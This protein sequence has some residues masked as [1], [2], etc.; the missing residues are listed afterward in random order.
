M[1]IGIPMEF[2]RTVGSRYRVRSRFVTPVWLMVVYTAATE[3]NI[4]NRKYSIAKVHC[5]PQLEQKLSRLMPPDLLAAFMAQSRP[6]ALAWARGNGRRLG[7]ASKTTSPA[8]AGVPRLVSARLLLLH[9]LDERCN[10]NGNPFLTKRQDLW[11]MLMGNRLLST[12]CS[13]FESPSR[14]IK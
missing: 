1:M 14:R 7:G 9:F 11:V 4:A 3:C 6:L 10:I 5:W 8:G 12:N 13:Y 2:V